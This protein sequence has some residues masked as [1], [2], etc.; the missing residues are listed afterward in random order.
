MKS[1][2]GNLDGTTKG[3]GAR[4]YKE[5]FDGHPETYPPA[6]GDSQRG[7]PGPGGAKKMTVSHVHVD[8]GKHGMKE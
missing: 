8:H 7:H 1:C 4:S 3:G 2:E 5:V 6:I